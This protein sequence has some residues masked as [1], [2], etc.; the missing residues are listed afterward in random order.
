MTRTTLFYFRFLLLI[1]AAITQFLLTP[2]NNTIGIFFHEEGKVRVSNNKWTLLVYKDL[3]PIRQAVRHNDKLLSTLSDLTADSSPRITAFKSTVQTHFSLL[4]RI[5]ESVSLKLSEVTTDSKDYAY[6]TKRGLING[7]GSLF[8]AI[9]GNLDSSDGEY[10]NECI[11]KIAHDERELETLLKNQISVTTSVIKSFN[12]TLQKLQI[13]E[14]T[15]NHDIDEIK[16]SMI[17]ISDSIKFYESQVRTLELCEFLMESYV[18]LENY[19]N[20]LLN[21]ITFA[22]LK[23]LHSSIINPK[24]LITSLQEVSRSLSKN[25]LPF[26][27][28]LTYVAQYLDVIELQ[29]FQTENKIVFVLTIPL[30]EPE[31]YTLYRNFPIPILDNRTGLSHIIPTINKYI[32]RDDDSLLYISPPNLDNCKLVQIKSYICSNL[33]QYPIDSDATCEAQLLRQSN[34]LPITCQTSIVLTSEY[35]VQELDQNY[36]LITVSGPL[37]VTIQC[38]RAEIITKVIRGNTLLRLQPECNSFI[39]STR[40][41]SKYPIEV[42]K[43]VTYRSHPVIIPYDCCKSFPA[44]V[45]VPEL[46]PLKLSNIDTADLNVAQHKLNQYSEQLEKLMDQPFV[47]KHIHWFTILTIILVVTLIALYIFCKCRRKK[48]T[49]LSLPATDDYPPRPRPGTNLIKRL[50]PKRRTSIHPEEPVPEEPI[51]LSPI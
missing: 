16:T 28:Y 11:D 45:H 51:I 20:D 2:V 50:I 15:F 22:R 4:S 39:G 37:P 6:R 48:P 33:L 13:D 31:T 24:D 9:T 12:S 8:K 23:I 18:Y 10:F 26:P 32:A 42:Y 46:K 35:H 19:L 21:S 47:S 41:H 17:D 36:W 14:L 1:P 5:A 3:E 7:I 27:T 25:N 44:K 49:R 40:V 30:L 38:G 43:N 34:Q 29:A